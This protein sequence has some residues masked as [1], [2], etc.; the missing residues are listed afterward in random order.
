MSPRVLALSAALVAGIVTGA[1]AA[2][3]CVGAS[4][5]FLLFI[6]HGAAQFDFYPGT[7]FRVDPP[8]ARIP[9]DTASAH[10]L[11]SGPHRIP[12]ILA[13]RACPV[14]GATLPVTAELALP[15]I[16]GPEMIVGCCSVMAQ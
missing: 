6:D 5:R 16:E 14:L 12:V 9:A 7:A 2:Y 11:T 4:P 3:M 15:G 13:P 10:T 8:A 1:Q